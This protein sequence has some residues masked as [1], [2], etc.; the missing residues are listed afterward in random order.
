MQRKLVV[1]FTK[2]NGAGNDFI[3]LDNRFYF[4]SPDELSVLAK[5]YCPRRTGIGADGLL[6]L[7]AAQDPQYDYRMTYYNADGSLGTMCGNGARCL[8]Q[9]AQ[10]AGIHADMYAFESDAGVYRAKVLEHGRVRLFV[11]PPQRMTV[12]VLP[13]TV[14]AKNIN[15]CHFI[16][17]GTEHV[18]CE[19]ATSLKELVIE[20]EGPILRYHEA[21]AP[22]GANVNFIE[23][24]DGQTLQV[25]TFEKGVEAETLACGT[26]AIASAV[27]ATMQGLVDKVPVTVEMVGGTLLVGFEQEEGTFTDVWLEGPTATIYRGT[28]EM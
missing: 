28:I 20:K 21:F 6:A 8:A 16:W 10:W 4:F 1:E 14:L 7:Q 9:F 2:M 17:I 27:M 3:I 25:R 26:G 15:A 19:V 22:T 23:R 12:E 11:Q 5:Q 24:I 13:S 18:V